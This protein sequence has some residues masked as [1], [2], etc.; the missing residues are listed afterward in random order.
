MEPYD[1]L[2]LGNASTH[3]ILKVD[4]IPDNDETIYIQNNDFDRLFFGGTGMNIVYSMAKLGAG[5]CAILTSTDSAYG[6]TALTELESVG[7]DTRF[8]K[9]MDGKA[10]AYIIED[11]SKRRLTILGGDFGKIPA[12]DMPDEVF[13]TAKLA[14]FSMD[15]KQNVDAFAEKLEK[16]GTPFAFS[17]RSDRIIFSDELLRRIVPRARLLFCNEYERQILE[18][19]LGLEDIRQLLGR[20]GRAEAVAVTKGSDGIWL[21][22]REDAQGVRLPPTAAE[23]VTDCTG[24]GDGFVAGFLYGWARGMAPLECAKL[25]ATASSFIIEQLGCITGSPDETRLLARYAARADAAR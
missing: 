20:K 12:C 23:R 1:F 10:T 18:Q 21:G 3:Y 11:E 2:V 4:R 24:A 13:R 7:V 8:V 6:L 22:T 16:N 25:G 14:V 9:V 19:V 17:M 5:R 15:S